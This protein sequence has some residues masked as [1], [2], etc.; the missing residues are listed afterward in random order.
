M[1]QSV[2]FW[3]TMRGNSRDF[4]FLCTKIPGG[5][6]DLADINP[7]ADCANIPIENRR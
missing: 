2:F 5:T 1:E 6:R 7:C 4:D 3:R